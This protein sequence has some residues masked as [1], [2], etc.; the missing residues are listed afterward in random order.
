MIVTVAAPVADHKKGN[1]VSREAGKITKDSM[2][3][4]TSS[5]TD[6]DLFLKLS[7]KCRLDRLVPFDAAAWEEPAWSIV[8]AHKE[9]AII[10][11]DDHALR[12]ESEPSP[13]PPEW[14]QHFGQVVVACS[15]RWEPFKTQENTWK[16]GLCAAW[17]RTPISLA[18]IPPYST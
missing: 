6:A 4:H 15:L 14:T 3:L 1:M 9:H 8:V 16:T 5:E 10:A 11:V 18:P 13:Q 2:E 17:P 12:A 7:G